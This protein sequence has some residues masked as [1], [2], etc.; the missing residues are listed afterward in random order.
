MRMIEFYKEKLIEYYGTKVSGSGTKRGYK[1]ED[2]PHKY[3]RNY[4]DNEKPDFGGGDTEMY[5]IDT[6]NLK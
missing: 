1:K 3:V 2:N 5:Y 4:C 6:L